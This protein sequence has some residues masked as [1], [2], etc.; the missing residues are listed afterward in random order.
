MSYPRFTSPRLRKVLQSCLG[1]REYDALALKCGRAHAKEPG[2]LS[3]HEA[4]AVRAYT[5]KK[6]AYYQTLNL[7]LRRNRSS[8]QEREFARLLDQALDKLPKYD[9]VVFRGVWLGPA[10]LAAVPSLYRV[11]AVFQWRAFS[12]AS[13]LLSKA[14]GANV[15]FALRSSSGCLLGRY[16][17]APREKEVLFPRNCRFKALS[18]K[19]V[20]RS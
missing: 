13:A 3:L 14:Y 2:L 6:V 10:Q 4:I 16:S 5:D 19:R 15:Y 11:G 20:R 12:S 7:N 18:H 8:A 9:G 17:A 1:E